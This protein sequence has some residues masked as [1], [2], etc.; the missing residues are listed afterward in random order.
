MARIPSRR[1]GGGRTLD[2]SSIF[3]VSVVAGALIIDSG[4]PVLLVQGHGFT[5]G[6]LIISVLQLLALA[7]P[8]FYRPNNFN[9]VRLYQLAPIALFAVMILESTLSNLLV[10]QYSVMNFLPSMYLLFPLLL[11]VS[12]R[13]LDISSDDVIWGLIWSAAFAA[14]MVIIDDLVHI[15][16][17][18]EMRRMSVFDEAGNT[19]R[20]VILKDSCVIALVLLASK[21]ISRPLTVREYILYGLLCALI[22]FPVF[23]E[24]ESRFAIIVTLL[25]IAGFLVTA[26]L[27]FVRRTTLRFFAVLAGLP[28]AFLAL[29]NFIAPMLGTDF[30]TYAANNNVD[31]RIK[32]L[33]YFFNLFKETYGLGVGHMSTS[34]AYDNVL[35]SVVDQSFNLNDLGIYASM[36]QF[37]VAGLII[38]LSMTFYL[39]YALYRMGRTAHNR[40]YELHM[41]ACYIVASLLQV[42]PTNFFTLSYSCIYGSLLWYIMC[43]SRWELANEGR[44]PR[45]SLFGDVGQPDAVR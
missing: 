17:L 18:L 9:L 8:F 36:L 35:S 16:A 22:A 14:V 10:F 43:R 11:Y 28:A 3:G 20:L 31:I 4:V 41:L 33:T 42:V 13:N 7:V 12:L 21:M 26:G 1:L 25:S 5:T 27:P 2:S 24:F 30:E 44:Q 38:V 39:I 6:R 29:R 34:P 37:G 15:P 40:H 19:N 23:F 45:P 32:S